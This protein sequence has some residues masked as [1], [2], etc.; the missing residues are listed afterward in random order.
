MKTLV[1]RLYSASIIRFLM[2]G[3]LNSLVGA[4]IMFGAYNLLHIPYW[5]S[6][7]LNYFIGSII[8]FFLNKYFT[9]RTKGE[10]WPQIWRFAVNVIVCYF[11]AYSV[12]QP[13]MKYLLS[14]RSQ[15]LQDN[16]AMLTGAVLFTALNYVGQRFFAFRE[17]REVSEI[18]TPEEDSGNAQS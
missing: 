1:K 7:A 18:S 10:L 9:F 13:L 5:P 4:A 12:A 2:V 15:K 17:K 8:S 3:V 16:V 6:T 11:I 14:G